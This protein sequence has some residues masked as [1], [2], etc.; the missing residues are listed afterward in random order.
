MS[1]DINTP[2]TFGKLIKRNENPVNDEPDSVIVFRVGV[3]ETN[4]PPTI[5]KAAKKM[6]AVMIKPNKNDSGYLKTKSNMS[7]IVLTAKPIFS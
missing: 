3:K 5:N 7:F 4:V 1:V 2:A 6:R